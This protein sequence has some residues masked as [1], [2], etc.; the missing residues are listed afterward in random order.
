[1]PADRAQP[2]TLSDGTLAFST[3]AT[4][5]RPL[6][7]SDLDPLFAAAMDCAEEAILNSLF[8]AQTTTGFGGHVR[9]AV[10]LAAVRRS[11]V[12]PQ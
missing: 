9:H 3:A 10:P 11:A 7:D 5:D 4:A 1:M 2:P 6:A 12:P 8:M